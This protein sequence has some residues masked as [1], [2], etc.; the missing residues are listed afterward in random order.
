[1]AVDNNQNATK[2]PLPAWLGAVA[3]LLLAGVLL[4][5][6]PVWA[7]RAGEP[8]SP[9]CRFAHPPQARGNAPTQAKPAKLVLINGQVTT[10]AFNRAAATK[11]LVIQYGITGAIAGDLRYPNLAVSQQSFLRSDEAALP[12]SRIKV[13]AWYQNGRVLLNL[14][15]DRSGGQLADPG[16]YQGTVSIVDQRVGRVDVPVTVTLSYPSWQ[17]VLE[18]LVLASIG[19]TWYIWVLRQKKPGTLA[20]GWDFLSYCTSMLGVL[21]IAAGVIAALGV[22]SATY[23]SSTDW[24]SAATQPLT[25]VGAMFSA[26]L[27]GASSVHIGAAAGKAKKAQNKASKQKTKAA[28]ADAGAGQRQADAAPGPG[29]GA[30]GPA[31]P[32]PGAPGPAAPAPGAPGPAAPAPA[33]LAP[34]VPAPRPDGGPDVP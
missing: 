12:A 32:A 34:A 17:L 13:A 9:P 23:L 22:Y 28:A 10:L 3:A 29:A 16:T 33:G 14:C 2:K 19:G 30:P 7:A 27:A 11:T 8:S 1:M 20:F 24:G 26:F 18:L 15:V 25:L 6:F 5:V 21:S 31:A 4:A